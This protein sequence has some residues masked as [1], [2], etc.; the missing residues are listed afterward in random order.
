MNNSH[1]GIKK[2]SFECSVMCHLHYSLDPTLSLLSPE[3]EEKFML[4]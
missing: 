3:L 1:L 2:S 4:L